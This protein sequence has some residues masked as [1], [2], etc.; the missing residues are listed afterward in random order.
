M[1]KKIF[2]ALMILPFAGLAQT[3]IVNSWRDPN[4]TIQNPGYHKIVVAALLN[5]Q[6]VR[7]QVEDYMVTLYP[8]A[9]TQSYLVMGD[10]LITNENAVSQKLKAGGFDGIVIMKQVDENT[11]QQYIPGRMPSTYNTWGGYWGYGWGGPRWVT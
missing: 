10:S 4:T 7:R 9:A 8:G 1:K 2:L 11:T 3:Q 6:G 5:D